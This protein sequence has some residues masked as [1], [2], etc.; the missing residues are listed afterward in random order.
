MTTMTCR[1][2]GQLRCQAVHDPSAAEL[3]TDA[4]LDN[5][6][7]GEAFSPTDLVATALATC[8]LTIMG[9]TAERYGLAIEGSEARV[10]K[11]MTGTGVR[12]IEQLTVWISLP[13]G[14]EAPQRDL[15][16]RAGEGCPVKRSL[17]GAVSMVLHWD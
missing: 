13:A 3:L 16:R 2:E 7:R 4:P 17:E 12:R 5:Q 6:G 10:E 15:L 9:I 14:L 11:T 8:I 1:Y